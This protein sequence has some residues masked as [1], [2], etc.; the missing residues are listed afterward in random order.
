[1]E[2][3]DRGAARGDDHRTTHGLVASLWRMEV[4]AP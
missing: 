3:A 2:L 1:L 4:R